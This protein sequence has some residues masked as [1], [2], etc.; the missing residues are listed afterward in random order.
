MPCAG[1]KCPETGNII[2]L[3]EAP[4]YFDK[5]GIMPGEVVRS[6]ALNNADP[7]RGGFHLSPSRLDP[8]INCR[9]QTVIERNF[10]WVLDPFTMWAAEEGTIFHR[11]L[12]GGPTDFQLP[13]YKYELLLPNESHRGMPGVVEDDRGVLHLE[14]VPGI[15]M[16]GRL[17]RLSPDGLEL[18]DFKT[19]RYAKTDY[20]IKR[21]WKLQLGMYALMAK[22]LGETTGVDKIVVWRIYRGAYDATK[23]FR[24]FSIKPMEEMEMLDIITEHCLTSRDFL[25]ECHALADEDAKME[26]VNDNVPLDGKIKRI[27][28][29]KKCTMYCGAK[30]LCGKID[31]KEDEA[32]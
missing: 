19:Q 25:M 6:L 31:G 24:R 22:K 17:D 15:L 5:A 10:D 21:D 32:F 28:N 16:N 30:D 2:S 18:G 14:I 26:Y 8:S 29:G 13:G 12:I 7:R 20:G 11:A 23:A 9:R 1:F 3:E 27:F 4:L